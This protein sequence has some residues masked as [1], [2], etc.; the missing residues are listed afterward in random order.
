[1]PLTITLLD[2]I[3]FHNVN[4]SNVVYSHQSVEAAA[5]RPARMAE[6]R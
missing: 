6:F 2:E 5:T 3:G 4:N 1:M